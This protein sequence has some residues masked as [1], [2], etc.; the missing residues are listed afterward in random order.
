MS[1]ARNRSD[2]LR[3]A[4]R[5]AIDARIAA[6]GGYSQPVDVIRPTPCVRGASGGVGKSGV[7]EADESAAVAVEEVDLDQARPRRN[8]VVPVPAE[9]APRETQPDGEV[10]PSKTK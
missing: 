3:M 1:F 7:S 6:C 8:L 10:D 2:P 4:G 5:T 9:S